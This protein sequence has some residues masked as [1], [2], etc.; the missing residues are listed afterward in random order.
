MLIMTSN[1]VID[2]NSNRI[3]NVAGMVSTTLFRSCLHSF[4]CLSYQVCSAFER[5][6]DPRG[7]KGGGDRFHSKLTPFSA[8]KPWPWRPTPR[9]TVTPTT[10]IKSVRSALR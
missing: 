7:G 2:R 3:D 8:A 1:I 6:Q 5:G 10:T 9:L 4:R